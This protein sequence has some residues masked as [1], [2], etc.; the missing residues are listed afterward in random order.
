MPLRDISL[1]L[2]CILISGGLLTITGV[3]IIALRKIQKK[4][5]VQVDPMT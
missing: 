1:A 5:P 3:G 4:L 2:L